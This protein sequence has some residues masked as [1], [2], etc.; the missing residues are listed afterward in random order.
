MFDL[1]RQY[2]RPIVALIVAPIQIKHVHSGVSYQWVIYEKYDRRGN[3]SP[4]GYGLLDWP[5]V[6]HSGGPQ[7]GSHMHKPYGRFAYYI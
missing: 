3:A 7:F 1:N 2:N 6:C 4:C 5:V